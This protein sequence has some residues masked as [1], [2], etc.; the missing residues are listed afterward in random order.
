MKVIVAG[1]R[2]IKDYGIVRQAILDSGLWALHKR[3][4][5]IVS[6]GAGGVDTLGEEFATRNGLVL[7]RMPA[8]WDSVDKPGAVIRYRNGKPYNA[9]AGHWRNEDMA[10]F[11]NALI[12][13]WDGY[14][15]GTKDMMKQ[16][17]DRDLFVYVHNMKEKKMRFFV[18]LNTASGEKTPLL[19]SEGEK[20][21]MF[22]TKGEA[23]TAVGDNLLGRAMGGY[24]FDIDDGEFA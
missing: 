11:A 13:V 7:H 20:V 5:E 10:K 9:A 21:A 2:S 3:K 22:N 15:N 23:F 14:S 16:A 19:D 4:L 18:M 1:S 12:A 8:D 17:Y 6:G 24:I